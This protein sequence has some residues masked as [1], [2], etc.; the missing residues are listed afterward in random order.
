MDLIKENITDFDL[1]N[2]SFIDGI[3][4]RLDRQESVFI[5][6]EGPDGSGK[7]TQAKYLVEN[8][9]SMGIEVIYTR[10]PGGE[11]LAEK[12]RSL[13]FDN[14][15]DPIT[16]VLLFTAAR[17]SHIEKILQPNLSKGGVVVVC[18]RYIGSTLAYQGSYKYEDVSLYPFVEDLHYLIDDYRNIPI[19]DVIVYCDVD[20]NTAAERTA[21]RDDNNRLDLINDTQNAKV[22]FELRKKFYQKALDEVKGQK[23]FN[24]EIIEIDTRC[25]SKENIQMIIL[26]HDWTQFKQSSYMFLDEDEVTFSECID[27]I[28]NYIKTKFLSIFK[29]EQS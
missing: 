4:E 12:I 29:K 20:Y 24:I 2:S 14:V 27:G 13:L 6:F 28:R 17:S 11:P 16:E 8:L 3:F 7:T 21:I 1:E 26:D 19:P 10:E 18:D 23:E 22:Q 15:M 25:L 5:T 9:R